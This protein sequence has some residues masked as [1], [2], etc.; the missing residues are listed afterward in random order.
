MTPLLLTLAALAALLLLG[1]LGA[2]VLLRRGGRYVWPP[3][4]RLHMTLDCRALPN[5]EPRVRIDINKEGER[6]GPLPACDPAELFRVLV[7]GGSAAECYF[8]DQT[9]SWPG[10]LEGLLARP[11]VRERLGRR[12]VHV[13]NVARSGVGAAEALVQ[14]FRGLAPRYGRLDAV[15]IMAG[16]ADVVNWLRQGAPEDQEPRD[17]EE[18]ELFAR[19]PGRSYGWRPRQTA[20]A[21]LARRLRARLLRPVVRRENAGKK[22][23]AARAMRA[24]AR[25]IIREMP[26]P[27]IMLDRFERHFREALR[28]A[29]GMARRVVVV[30]Q[31]WFHKQHSPEEQACLW[32]GGRGNPYLETVDTYYAF[33]VIAG[34]MEKVDAR[35]AALCRESGAAR[36]EL[37]PVL[38]RSLR[39]YYDF[40]HFTPEGAQ[41][42]AEAV[43]PAV[44]GEAPAPVGR[45]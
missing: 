35:C 15:V 45:G 34:L 38:E 39:T 44:A 9:T 8:L 30:Q 3:G 10:A 36:V 37:M 20:L 6:G 25:T 12:H 17:L 7:A 26:D 4:M 28:L 5:L 14:V 13:G 21:E 22:L 40:F 31:P 27:T 29:S 32:N 24:D 33:E 43:L 1:E 42:V 11:E 23:A 41:R 18:D 16:A 2:R 19:H